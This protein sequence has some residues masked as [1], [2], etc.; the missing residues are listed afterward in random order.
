MGEG[1]SLSQQTQ[2]PFLLADTC[3]DRYPQLVA[4]SH[5]LDPHPLMEMM[6]SLQFGIGRAVCVCLS[7]SNSDLSNPQ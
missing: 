3:S 7:H 1:K 5:R 6:P 2:D 4:A